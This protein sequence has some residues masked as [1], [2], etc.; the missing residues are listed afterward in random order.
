MNTG[1]RQREFLQHAALG[2]A[3]VA[4]VPARTAA[5]ADAVFC[6]IRL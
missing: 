1:T 5:G 6:R 3:G 2:L 4:T